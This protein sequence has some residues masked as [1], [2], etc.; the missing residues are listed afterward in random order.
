MAQ[1]IESLDLDLIG[2]EEILALNSYNI[3]ANVAQVL[4]GFLLKISLWVQACA[5]VVDPVVDAWCV[6]FLQGQ[7]VP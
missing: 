5:S 7:R 6:L 4:E 2:C 3:Q 1:V